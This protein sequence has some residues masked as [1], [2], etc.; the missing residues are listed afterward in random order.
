MVRIHQRVGQ[1]GGAG[2]VVRDAAEQD[3]H[4]CARLLRVVRMARAWLE[5]GFPARGLA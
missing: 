4:G 5:A 1:I 3:A 2:E